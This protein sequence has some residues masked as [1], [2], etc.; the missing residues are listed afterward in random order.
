MKALL[1]DPAETRS[2]LMTTFNNNNNNNN[3]IEEII[4]FNKN[5][6]YSKSLEPF[7]AMFVQVLMLANFSDSYS[8]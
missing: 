1:T 6:Y 2:P 4:F 7:M 5:T 8:P 3:E